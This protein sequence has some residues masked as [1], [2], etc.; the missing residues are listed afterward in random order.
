LKFYRADRA[1]AKEIWILDRGISLRR[2]VLR[3]RRL[4]VDGQ[5]IATTP[6][7]EKELGPRKAVEQNKGKE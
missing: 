3:K 5:A 1:R 2:V 4:P 7:G 6:E